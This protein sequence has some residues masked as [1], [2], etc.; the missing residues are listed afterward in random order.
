MNEN[1][2]IGLLASGWWSWVATLSTVPPPQRTKGCFMSHCTPGHSTASTRDTCT[3]ECDK[4]RLQSRPVP[5]TYVV[6]NRG[7]SRRNFRASISG[8]DPTYPGV[9]GPHGGPIPVAGLPLTVR[10]V[11]LE[12]HDFGAVFSSRPTTHAGVAVESFPR[13]FGLSEAEVV[14]NTRT[15]HEGKQVETGTRREQAKCPAFWEYEVCKHMI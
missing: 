11:Q 2:L 14:F 15:R 7:I 10:H 9:Q 5:C 12:Y 4:K 1:A 13:I 8:P 3:A 6:D